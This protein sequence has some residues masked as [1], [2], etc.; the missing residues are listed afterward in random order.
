MIELR[1]WAYIIELSGHYCSGK[2][3]GIEY[4]GSLVLL[5]RLMG[6]V[7]EAKLHS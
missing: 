1:V 4:A 7:I 2:M 5:Y 6:W 3:H